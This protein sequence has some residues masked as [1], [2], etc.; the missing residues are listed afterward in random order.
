M[1][2]VP[3]S[4][5]KCCPPGGTQGCNC[6]EGSDAYIAQLDFWLLC[7][8]SQNFQRAKIK[9]IQQKYFENIPKAEKIFHR[10][11]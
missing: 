2:S 5:P 11:F 7:F 1:T 9:K 8:T 3:I 10:F 4:T 6:K